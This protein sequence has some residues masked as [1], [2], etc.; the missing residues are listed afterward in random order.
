M[1]KVQ[2]FRDHPTRRQPPISV[3][4]DFNAVSSKTL[5]ALSRELSFAG[6]EQARQ[7]HSA[8][9]SGLMAAANAITKHLLARRKAA[10]PSPPIDMGDEAKLA[11]FL[12]QRQEADP[13]AVLM[14]KRRK[15]EADR[16][17]AGREARRWT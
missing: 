8:V 10:M 16:V 14:R 5:A 6:R 12:Q 17:L 4:I 9:A 13:V 7:H 3:T 15:A 2:Y 1:G 11:K